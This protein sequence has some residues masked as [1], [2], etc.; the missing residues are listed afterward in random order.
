M[1]V[2]VRP[3]APL[4]RAQLAGRYRGNRLRSRRLFAIVKPETYLDRPIPL[5]LPI[6][7]YDGHI[8]AFT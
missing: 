1:H 4:P 2:Q 6:V 8:P 7:F 5:R 3:S